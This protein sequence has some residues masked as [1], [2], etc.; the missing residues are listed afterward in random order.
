[1]LGEERQ[2]RHHVLVLGSHL[3]AGFLMQGTH[4]LAEFIVQCAHFPQ[5]IVDH[6]A[7]FPSHVVCPSRISRRTE[8]KVAADVCSLADD[9]T[10]VA[11]S[12]QAGLDAM[13]ALRYQ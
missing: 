1:M 3:R 4:F 8:E 6:H 9:A 2:P 13:R 12:S 10:I 11:R 7:H 5:G